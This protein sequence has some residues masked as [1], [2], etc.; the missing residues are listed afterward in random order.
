MRTRNSFALMGVVLALVLFALTVHGQTDSEALGVSVRDF[1]AV[2]DGK[3][4][5]SGAFQRAIDS[6]RGDIHV[7][8][9]RYRFAKTVVA[10]LDR[11]GPLSIMGSGTATIIMAGPGP[12]LKLVGTHEGTASPDTV[13][14]D[15]R[16]NQRMPI[17][18]GLEIVGAAPL[19]CGI[20]ASGT[21]KAT[22]SEKRDARGNWAL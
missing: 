11:F 19:A 18:S 8:R 6:G 7:R 17:V 12:A 9:G 20:E 3:A 15:V 1:G 22:F 21:M 14:E 10:D 5:D 2:G 13:K 16:R 4:D